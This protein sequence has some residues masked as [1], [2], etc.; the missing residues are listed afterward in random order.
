MSA[1]DEPPAGATAAHPAQGNDGARQR[2][3]RSVVIPAPGGVRLDGELTAPRAGGGI[4][5]F[6]HGSGSGRHSPR[7]QFV[8]RAL[9]E[10]GLGTLLMDL[11]T[12]SEEV[13]DLRTA[14]LR[15]DIELL[16]ARVISAIDWVASA[17]PDDA[18]AIGCFGASTGAAAAL[19]AAAQRPQTVRA[20]VSRGG[21]PDLAGRALGDVRAPTLLI[22]GGDDRPVI[23]MN[24]D[25]MRALRTKRA[26]EI[27]PGA[28]HL[29]AEP[30][31]LER[32]AELA[33]SWFLRHL[34]PRLTATPLFA[35]RRDA[36]RRLAVHLAGYGGRD[37]V[38]V[39]G[40]PRGG[41]P[42]AYE[43][44]RALQ[45]PLD[46]FVVRKLGA[47][48]HEELA[49]G[50]IASGGARVLNGSV[51]RAYRISD[52]DVQRVADR[53]AVELARREQAY[54]GKRGPLSVEG[55][56]VIVVDDG[57]A[58]GASM[59][60]AIGALRER[61]AERVVAA[62][63][64]SSVATCAELADLVDE[65]VCA[66]TPEPFLAV[67]A[68]YEDFSATSDDEVRRLLAEDDAR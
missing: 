14:Q 30:G 40:L 56:T 57:L 43:V 29:F 18:T 4:V 10:R 61:R 37:D 63:P 6:A 49:M 58:T 34:G 60:A 24:E 50:A 7:N 27:V 65:M 66:H 21:R 44:A 11:L 42:V 8:A 54:R 19:V 12:S 33:G 53:E 59:R 26:L 5:V 36:G 39:L 48:G 15:F 62:V 64:V 67:G 1:R 16:A 17:C 51:I 52:E 31:A 68:W 35:D 47:P 20:V 9:Q 41:V 46:V 22:V 25:A 23:D 32:V 13:E 38:Q 3:Q 28:T 2:H 55:R 45:A